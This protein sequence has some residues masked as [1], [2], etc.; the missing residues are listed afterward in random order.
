MEVANSLA[1]YDMATITLVKVFILQAPGH[2]TQKV[3]D[4]NYFRYCSKLECLS[5]CV[6]FTLV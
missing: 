1:Y 4:C 3:L 2:V 6:P 5:L